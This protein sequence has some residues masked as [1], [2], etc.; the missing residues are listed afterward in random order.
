MRAPGGGPCE[1]LAF[2][3][4]GVDGQ[5]ALGAMAVVPGA[6]PAQQ[7][8]VVLHQPVSHLGLR[9]DH[10]HRHGLARG[11]PL[12]QG[13]LGDVVLDLHLAGAAII[14]LDGE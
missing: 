9:G 1:A 5:V 3:G 4:A 14:K 8:G 6:C 2:Q 12:A 10:L 7:A 13:E 11:L